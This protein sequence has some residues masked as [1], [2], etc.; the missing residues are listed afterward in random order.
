MTQTRRLMLAGAIT[1][2][3]ALAL[4]AVV[5]NTGAFTRSDASN[6]PPIEISVDGT[7]FVADESA[8][9]AVDQ[10][11]FGGGSGDESL[12]SGDAWV[13]DDDR[14]GNSHDHDAVEREG[15]EE[16]DDDD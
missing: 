9:G 5:A 2:M 1:I 8:Q 13:N 3:T 6:G 15:H 4:F 16:H 12:E 7:A 14:E 10:G 11:Q